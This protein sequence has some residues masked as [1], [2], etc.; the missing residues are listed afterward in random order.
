[1]VFGE[2]GVLTKVEGP[3]GLIRCIHSEN[4]KLIT[5][6]SQWFA[7]RCD[8]GPQ[9][10]E[11]IEGRFGFNELQIHETRSSIINKHQQGALSARSS[12]SHELTPVEF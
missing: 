8:V 10:G 4:T 12:N 7:K 1:M 6:T 2:H 11:V 9:C 5:A 3:L